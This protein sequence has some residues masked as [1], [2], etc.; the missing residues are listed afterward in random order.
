MLGR[1]VEGCMDDLEESIAC[2]QEWKVICA[3]KMDMLKEHSSRKEYWDFS[4]DEQIFAEVDAFIQRCRD[5][6]EICEGQLQFAL[7]GASC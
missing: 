5:L 6:K 4:Q 1:N 3:H 2:C 7:R